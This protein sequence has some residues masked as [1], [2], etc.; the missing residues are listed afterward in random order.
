MGKEFKDVEFEGNSMY[1]GPRVT[2]LA[3]KAF[4]LV[5]DNGKEGTLQFL[6]GT[7]LAWTPVGGTQRSERYDCL[8]IDED[9]YFVNIEPK[10]LHPRLGLVLV[11]DLEQSLV[12]ALF[13][14]Q[15]VDE[16]YP[17]KVVN[18]F[19]FGAIRKEDGTLPQVRH[20]FTADLVGSRI[21][22]RYSDHFA[23]SH[24]YYDPNYMRAPVPIP[25]DRP[26]L[27][28]IFRKHPYDVP[29]SYVKIKENIYF[30]S[31]I[32][33]FTVTRGRVGSSLTL[34]MDISRLH[35][36]GRS[37]GTWAGK[38]ENYLFSALGTW[39]EPSEEDMSPKSPYRV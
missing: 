9:T 31:F 21:R 29:C 4:E 11:L 22:W 32:E 12:T 2:E 16:K 28:E 14:R 30:V 3:G 19:V 18:E 38:W 7:T 25:K 1:R 15:E 35:D 17:D 10:N 27:E 8:K 34:L 24:I 6:T 26:E 39:E 5:L 37:F 36:V 20:G 23:I 33:D 13:S